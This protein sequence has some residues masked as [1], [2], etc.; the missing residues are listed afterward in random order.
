MSHWSKKQLIHLDRRHL[1]QLVHQVVDSVVFECLSEF[2]SLLPAETFDQLDDR[3]QLVLVFQ[4]VYE[5]PDLTQ[6]FK[7]VLALP[8]WLGALLLLFL[9][10]V[11]NAVVVVRVSRSAVA[12]LAADFMFVLAGI[13]VDAEVVAAVAGIAVVVVAA[14]V[15]AVVAVIVV[16]AAVAV[17]VINC[18]RRSLDHRL[19]H[20]T[21]LTV[22]PLFEVRP[23]LVEGGCWCFS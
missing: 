3:R 8:T 19:D 1:L 11:F 6:G 4:I 14:A 16:V 9:L 2:L 15:V 18:T 13:A 22:S 10:A 12:L 5:S 23:Q 17:A 20:V 21:D 7:L